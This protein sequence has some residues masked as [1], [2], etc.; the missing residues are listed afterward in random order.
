MKIAVLGVGAIGGVIGGYLA[1]A[2]RD[3]TLIDMWPANVDR[4]KESGLTVRPQEA[5][6]TVRARALHLGE[7][8]AASESYD[9]VFISVK[10]YDT[11]WSAKLIQPYLASG[12]YVVS[13]QN[14]I[15]DDVIAGV[16]GWTR[17]VG[18]VVTL[19]AGM[20]E[21]GHVL[22]TSDADRLSFKV[23]ELTGLA[24]RRAEKLCALLDDVGPTKL[25][26]NLWGERWSKLATN[27]MANALAG[28]TG[29]R[30]TEVRREP[31]TRD[32]AI[33]VAAELVDVAQALGVTVEPI[34]GVAPDMFRRALGD[35]SAMEEV[36]G[37][38][39]ETSKE[40]RE[41]R[42]SLA[43]DVMKGRKTEVSFLNGLVVRHGAATGVPTPVNKAVL[44]LTKRVESG[45][46]TPSLS[47]LDQ[48]EYRGGAP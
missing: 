1:R 6:F 23:G 38:M 37:L 35:G 30:S 48:I 7:V 25:T 29:L 11:E 10:S 43:Q 31:R 16:V 28:I 40:L 12:G 42:P 46:L 44:D 27:S 13:A 26:T 22:R 15:N 45:E 34:G 24:S 2:G 39:I 41:G 5:E 14:G 8:S 32:L 21:P 33:R 4:I 3:V 19:G 17:V 36:T 9:V 47:N 20:Y 18:C